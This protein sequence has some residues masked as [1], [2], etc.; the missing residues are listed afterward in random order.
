MDLLGLDASIPCNKPTN[1]FM[2]SNI[3]HPS[4]KRRK[5]KLIYRWNGSYLYPEPELQYEHIAILEHL[6]NM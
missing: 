3:E 2:K 6:I 4:E 5:D 1:I